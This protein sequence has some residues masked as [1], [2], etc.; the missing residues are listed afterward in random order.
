MHIQ[1]VT[2]SVSEWHSDKVDWSGKNANFAALIV[3]MVMSLE[4]VT[5]LWQRDSAT[6]LSVEIL[7][8]Q[9][10]PIV[11]H[12]LRDTTFS[13]FYTIPECDRHTQ[14]NRQTDTTTACT[15]LSIASRG[16]NRPYCSA[17]QV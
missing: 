17:H 7:Q 6:Q 9:N 3:G 12:Y 2:H 14:T 4:Q 11:W 16:K 5:L 8:L 10:I 1:G 13:R 15:V